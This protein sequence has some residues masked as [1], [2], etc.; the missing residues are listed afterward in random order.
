MYTYM[1]AQH[2]TSMNLNQKH[3]PPSLQV[4][5]Q[6]RQGKTDKQNQAWRNEKRD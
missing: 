2:S 4:T 5:T 3:T 1:Q 6:N